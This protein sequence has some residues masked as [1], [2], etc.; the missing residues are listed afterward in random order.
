M[1][2]KKF[3]EESEITKGKHIIKNPGISEALFT[4]AAEKPWVRFPLPEINN[5]LI[6]LDSPPSPFMNYIG[7][8]Q[9]SIQ[10]LEKGHPKVSS[11]RRR[12]CWN[13]SEAKV[14]VDKM[15]TS[16][17]SMGPRLSACGSAVK[18]LGRGRWEFCSEMHLFIWNP[19][20]TNFVNLCI[21]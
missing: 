12:R 3:L 10:R 5:W 11:N 6:L 8:R 15:E 7:R 2:P 14:P 16:S 4:L 13:G 19:V 21:L 18:E 1:I 17:V 20:S 9:D